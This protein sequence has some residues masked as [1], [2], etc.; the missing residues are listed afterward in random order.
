MKS[1]VSMKYFLA[2]HVHGCIDKGYLILMHLHRDEYFL[3][4]PSELK[5][6]APYLSG[7]QNLIKLD[8]SDRSYKNLESVNSIIEHLLENELI[9][10]DNIS[11]KPLISIYIPSPDSPFE[12]IETSD[13]IKFSWHH[14]LNILLSGIFSHFLLHFVPIRYVIKYLGTRPG[15]INKDPSPRLVKLAQIFSSLRPFLIRNRICLYDSISFYFF[16]RFYDERPIL[17]VG[18]EA[19]PFSAHCWAQQRGIILNDVPQNIMRYTPIM[20]I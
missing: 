17:I 1:E 6:L 9:T 12:Q 7:D 15:N 16:C 3:L 10:K 19:E 2:P 11:G 18:V 13:D 14:I 20:T 4:D 8:V 5:E